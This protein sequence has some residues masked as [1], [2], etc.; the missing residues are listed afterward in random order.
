M[1]KCVDYKDTACLQEWAG[2]GAMVGAMI[3]ASEA[4]PLVVGKVWKCAE[5]KA[6]PA[7]SIFFSCLYL[8]VCFPPSSVAVTA[9]FQ[10]SSRTGR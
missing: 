8:S 5:Q 6:A 9:S 4:E 10:P 1:C 3:G 7:P 2:A